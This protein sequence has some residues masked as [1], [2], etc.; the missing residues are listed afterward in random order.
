MAF[1]GTK[2]K[3]VKQFTEEEISKII[4]D[5]FKKDDWGDVDPSFFKPDLIKK[6]LKNPEELGD[7]AGL[8]KVVKRIT[9]RI[10]AR[11]K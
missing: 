10:N 6:A 7:M 2:Q 1:P 11:I 3:E 4:Y 8:E 9:K 5:E